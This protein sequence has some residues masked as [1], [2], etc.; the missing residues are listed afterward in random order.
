MK[1]TLLERLKKSSLVKNVMTLSLGTVISQL[2]G[3]LLSPILAR[4]FSPADYGLWGIF[5]S[6]ALI[7][8]IFITGRYE[9]AILRPK[10]DSDALNLVRLCLII[11]LGSLII[12]SVGFIGGKVLG[13]FP[14]IGS[15]FFIGLILYLLFNSL[16]QIFSYYSNREERYKRIASGSVTRNVVQGISRLC[17]GFSGYTKF[18]LIYGAVLG[19]FSNAAVLAGPIKCVKKVFSCL[20]FKE[21]KEQARIYYRFPLYEMPS[22]ALNTLSTNVPLLLLAYFFSESEIGYFSMAVSLMFLP[23]SFITSAQ[24]QVYYKNT[25]VINDKEIGTLTLK[26]FSANFLIAG[27]GLLIIGLFASQIFS[28]FLGKRW[29][30]AGDYAACFTPWLLMVSCF[31]PISTIFLLKDKQHQA[32]IFNLTLFLSRI[33]AVF[34]GGLIFK[35]MLVSMLLYGFVGFIVWTIQGIFIFRLSKSVLSLKKKLILICGFIL[36]ISIWMIRMYIMLI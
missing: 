23:I 29:L 33:L 16:S 4:I 19:V 8:A 20:Q 30:L 31:S 15:A 18:G 24:S 27:L 5:S 9:V 7:C 25:T 13:F 34:I 11:C 21:I 12:L 36:F 22:A 14:E 28:I 3:I 2:I 26:I 10:K 32:F 17:L 6:T 1:I 35:S